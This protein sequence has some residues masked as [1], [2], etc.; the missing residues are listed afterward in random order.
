MDS[1]DEDMIA[2]T[3]KKRRILVE[4]EDIAGN[5]EPIGSGIVRSAARISSKSK[6]ELNEKDGHANATEGE[7]KKVPI[8]GLVQHF[9]SMENIASP[10]P[11]QRI[12]W[13]LAVKGINLHVTAQPG[14]GKTLAYLLPVAC[15]LEQ[16]GHT[17]K[18]KPDNPLVLV[19]L[20]TRE[21]AQ[22]VA[23]V[24][25]KVRKHCATLRVA[26]LT[27]GSEKGKQIDSL[28]RR[29]HAI[30]ATPGRLVDLLEEG[31]VSL[32]A[33]LCLNSFRMVC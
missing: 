27:G 8:P 20:P 16:Q 32:G 2:S 33:F 25:R 19:L 6:S 14:S 10:L 7:R 24:C 26:C 1:S 28:K 23:M 3:E 15:K 5:N 4:K 18:T 22:Q 29:P 13:P 31:S 12:V 21:L 30:V 17:M 11:L 9:L